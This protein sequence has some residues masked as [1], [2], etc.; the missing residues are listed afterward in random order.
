MF[1]Y[2]TAPWRKL[3]RHSFRTLDAEEM[4]YE[5]DGPGI[6][7]LRD[8]DGE[9]NL[10][11]WSDEDSRNTQYLVVPAS[12]GIIDALKLGRLSVHDALNQPRC[13]LVQVTNDGVIDSVYSGAYD[14]I[15]AD[16]RPTEGT[17]L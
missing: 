8:A 15:P 13:W 16:C 10:A 11:C 14:V 4:L 2:E 9:L 17:M 6:F 1:W 5:F 7:T 12:T 3:D